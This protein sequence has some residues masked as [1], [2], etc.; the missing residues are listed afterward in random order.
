MTKLTK[1]SLSQPLSFENYFENSFGE[2]FH[3][4][5]KLI[6][7]EKIKET[8]DGT[9]SP[10]LDKSEVYAKERLLQAISANAWMKKVDEIQNQAIKPQPGRKLFGLFHETSETTSPDKISTHGLDRKDNKHRP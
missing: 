3:D 2:Q 9:I 6:E 10:H 5:Y 7:N 4:Y 8:L 1:T